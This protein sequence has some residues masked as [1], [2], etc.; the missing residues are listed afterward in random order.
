MSQNRDPE[1][2]C[3]VCGAESCSRCGAEV[4]SE[5]GNDHYCFGCFEAVCC[6]CSINMELPFGRHDVEDHLI[7][8]DEEEED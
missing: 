7:D 5:E 2:G 1:F 6:D 8:P 4:E 3:G